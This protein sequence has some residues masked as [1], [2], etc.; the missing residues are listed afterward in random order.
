MLETRAGDIA[1]PAHRELAVPCIGHLQAELDLAP[2]DAGDRAAGTAAAARAGAAAPEPAL[3]ARAGGSCHAPAPRRAGAGHRR[4]PE[5]TASVIFTSGSCRP[6]SDSHAICASAGAR[7]AQSPEP[8]V[9]TPAP[10]IRRILPSVLS[11]GERWHAQRGG[12]NPPS[13][14]VLRSCYLERD[15]A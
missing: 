15:A 4:P 12:L 9:E 13:Q 11:G 5:A 14:A 1:L 10:I 3:R 6:F 2:D 7:P 8:S